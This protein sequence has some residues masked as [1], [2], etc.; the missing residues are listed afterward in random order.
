MPRP[1]LLPLLAGLA[2]AGGGLAALGSALVPPPPA[3]PFVWPDPART[4]AP[5]PAPDPA[6]APPEGWPDAFGTFVPVPE[7]APQPEPDLVEWIDEDPPPDDVEADL[8]DTP[9]PEPL[10]DLRLRGLAM[11]E[12]GGWALVS[13]LEGEALIRPGAEIEGGHRLVAVGP[14]GAIFDGPDGPWTLTFDPEDGSAAEPAPPSPYPASLGRWRE[15]VPQM[16]PAGYRQG[17]GPGPD[18]LR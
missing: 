4:P 7:P 14:E 18:N 2:A 15:M 3:A 16:P 6:A 10:P 9:Q 11:D 17:F 12:A 8:F 1:A 13:T 5:A